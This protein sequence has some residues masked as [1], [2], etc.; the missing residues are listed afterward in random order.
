MKLRNSF[1][2]SEL[3]PAAAMNAWSGAALPPR[4]QP[5]LRMPRTPQCA[6][7]DRPR[8]W[9]GWILPLGVLALAALFVFAA[10]S[11]G[12]GPVLVAIK[13]I[14]DRGLYC[15]T[16][17]LSRDAEVE[18]EA[19]ASGWPKE[20]VLFTYAWLL[21]LRTR[22][23]VWK[24]DAGDVK[25][26]NHDNVRAKER[27]QLPAGDYAVYFT[28]QGDRF[29]VKKQI[30]FLKLFELGTIDIRGG[31]MVPWDRYGKPSEWKV[32]VRAVEKDFPP[33]AVS[34]PARP[35]DLGAIV[36]F[37]KME[38]MNF[39]RTALEVREKVRLRILAIGEYVG[40]EQSFC[41]AAW[42]E[43]LDSCERV[44]EMT[45]I[46]TKPAGGAKKNRIFD[47]EV[48][49]S[50]GRYMVCYASD[51]SHAYDHWNARPPFDPESWGVTLIPVESVGSEVVAVIPDPPDE[52]VIARIE[53][54]GDSEFQ[55]MGFG[56][57]HGTDVCVRCLGEWDRSNSRFFDYGWIE[58]ARTL[59]KVWTMEFTHGIYAAGEARNRL[60]TERVRLGAGDYYVCY[61]T[62]E[63]H[64]YPKWHNHPPF[65]PKSWGISLRG[66]G[67]DFSM[68]WV[69]R[70][71]EADGPVA[72]IRIAPVGDDVRRRVRFEVI[73]PIKF[74]V[75]ALGEGKRRDMFDFGYLVREDTGETVW[76]MDYADT[77]PAGGDRKNRRC[78][79]VL[80][81][82]PGLYS[83]HYRSDD[84][85]SF[86]DWNTDPPDDAHFWGVTLIELPAGGK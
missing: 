64:S 40:R 22:A 81:L 39:A 37:R 84:S 8:G 55:R 69:R 18:I 4:S 41:D 72:V 2:E 20:D 56:L 52:N 29:P 75:I 27:I 66:I 15:K 44:W 33:G 36:Q 6:A 46:N 50:P 34:S 80:S 61:A 59:D 23:V 24:M 3:A 16:F 32:T 51:D 62:D 85:H 13:E 54:V 45:L 43:D 73:T 1:H 60:V 58:D 19:I 26:M 83:L 38:S 63:A 35:P 68:D 74:K 28:A 57:S 79:R 70:F 7:A 76:E 9:A 31:M 71:D 10:P 42:I 12:K 25:K 30:K 49:I 86:D 21:D 5:T 78:E 77:R 67:E 65:D 48:S 47:D 53:R 82:E 11:W 17:S 14:P